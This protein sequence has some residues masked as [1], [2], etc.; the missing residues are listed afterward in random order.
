MVISQPRT[1]WEMSFDRDLLIPVTFLPYLDRK[2]QDR[3]FL[4]IN[5]LTVSQQLF[6]SAAKLGV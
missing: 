3:V 6:L 5:N 4:Y 1:V 2:N